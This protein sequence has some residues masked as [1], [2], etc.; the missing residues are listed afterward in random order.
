MRFKFQDKL[1]RIAEEGTRVEHITVNVIFISLM[2]FLVVL[3][4][5]GDK[6]G[7]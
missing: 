7:W 5:Y 6:H 3:F 1:N 4:I 2:A